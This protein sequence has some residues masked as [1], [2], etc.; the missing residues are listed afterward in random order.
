[1][2]SGNEALIIQSIC[3]NC[4]YHEECKLNDYCFP[5]TNMKLPKV[6]DNVYDAI[7][8]YNLKNLG[9]KFTFE[10]MNNQPNITFEIY[11]HLTTYLNDKQTE[12]FKGDS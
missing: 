12:K 10:E 8:L 2:A 11:K 1:M 9:V 3:Y 6:T 7:K 5:N 4:E